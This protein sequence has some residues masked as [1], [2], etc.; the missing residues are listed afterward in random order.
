MMSKCSNRDVESQDQGPRVA[1]A[2]DGK[3]LCRREPEMNRESVYSGHSLGKGKEMPVGNYGF[4]R[5]FRLQE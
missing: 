3:A 5:G 1:R 4:C 2:S